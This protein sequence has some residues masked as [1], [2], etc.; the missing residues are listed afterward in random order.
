MR[1]S[2]FL[3]SVDRGPIATGG[4]LLSLAATVLL[5]LWLVLVILRSG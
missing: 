4:G 5:S 3:L 2:I 1:A